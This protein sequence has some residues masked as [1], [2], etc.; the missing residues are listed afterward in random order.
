MKWR[1]LMWKKSWKE[2]PQVTI[3]HHCIKHMR[4]VFNLVL[5]TDNTIP[6]HLHNVFTRPPPGHWPVELAS[7]AVSPKALDGNASPWGKSWDLALATEGQ[8]WDGHVIGLFFSTPLQGE[9]INRRNSAENGFFHQWKTV[10]RS[11][12]CPQLIYIRIWL[13]L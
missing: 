2:S 11:V 9:E 3:L 5:L 1:K 8:S 10:S 13:I 7:L 6:P 4:F 12:K